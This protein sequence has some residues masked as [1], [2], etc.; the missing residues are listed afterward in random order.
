MLIGLCKTPCLCL[1]KQKEA[2]DTM[3]DKVKNRILAAI[4]A[5]PKDY[6]KDPV[7]KETIRCVLYG[8]LIDQG[9][10]PVPAYRDPRYQEG[11]ADMVGVNDDNVITVAFCSNPTIE[12]T[13]I[14]TLERIGCEQKTIISFSPNQKKVEMSTFF[15]KPGIEHIYIYGE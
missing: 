13:D 6:L 1:Q 8:Y 15:L 12:L 14:K 5:I 2:D 3:K 11:P 4:R 7:V 10:H 9:L